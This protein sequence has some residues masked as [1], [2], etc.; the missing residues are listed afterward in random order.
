MIGGSVASQ[1]AAPPGLA[2]GSTSLQPINVAASVARPNQTLQASRPLEPSAASS[3][4]KG[5]SSGNFDDLWNLSLGV[6]STSSK[7]TTSGTL[8]GGSGKSI[9]DLEKEKAEVGM[10]NMGSKSS[11]T[12]LGT[13][14]A[15]RASS[16]DDLLL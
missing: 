2:W 12:T 13:G 9:R 3:L 11:D 16:D 14:S 4:N 1:P 15:M 5:S 6:G 8:G 7:S 10:W